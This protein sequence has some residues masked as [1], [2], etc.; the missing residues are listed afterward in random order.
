[1][2]QVSRSVLGPS[3]LFVGDTSQCSV[4]ALKNQQLLHWH[5][6]LAMAVICLKLAP[7]QVHL[8]K[9]NL[10]ASHTIQT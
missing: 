1:M 2:C 9:E 5:S 3:A 10:L 7:D 4:P 6:T 8:D